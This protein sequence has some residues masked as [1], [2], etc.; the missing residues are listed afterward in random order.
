MNQTPDH[1]WTPDPQLLAAYF[2]GE[3]EGRDDVADV[4]KH[5]EAWLETHPEGADEGVV[6]E[7]LQK[8]WADTTPVEPSTTTWNAT[9]DR[10]EAQRR[11]PV[12]ATRRTRWLFF[13]ACAASVAL[14][15]ALL[16]GLGVFWP[17]QR[18]HDHFV[19]GDVD[20]VYPVA[21]ASEV[22]ILRI[23]SEDVDAVVVGTMPVD[24]P[25][26]LVSSG[27][28]TIRCKCPNVNVRQDPPHRPMVWPRASA[29]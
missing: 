12:G 25:L 6:Q 28:V 26:E 1:D 21:L 19:A 16:G 23:E 24:G 18:T 5:I 29:D 8:V 15:L 14:F 7:R 4:R 3:L 13:G 10:I 9:L 27:D 22:T 2:D 11:Q 20:E 17:T